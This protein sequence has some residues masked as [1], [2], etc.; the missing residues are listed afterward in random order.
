MEKTEWFDKCFDKHDFNELNNLD[1]NILNYA[2]KCFK[3]TN[4]N[5]SNNS[6]FLM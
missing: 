1:Y 3:Q 5:P 4:P 2:I 6:I